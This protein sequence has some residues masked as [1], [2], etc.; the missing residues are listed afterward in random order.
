LPFIPDDIDTIYFE[1]SSSKLN[2]E[3]VERL[4]QQLVYLNRFPHAAVDLEGHADLVE[5]EGVGN[6][7]TK[8]ESDV[9][10]GYARALAIKTY[11]VA[12]GIAKTRLFIR[13][14]G[15]SAILPNDM[16]PDS[17]SKLR[18]VRTLPHAGK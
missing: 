3:A 4:D 16:S 13:S 12:R 15:S 2:N 10:L 18:H 11:F 17:L 14:Y 1:P 9:N 8:E 7:E 6:A 5:N